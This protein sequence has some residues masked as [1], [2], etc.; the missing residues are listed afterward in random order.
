MP[1]KLIEKRFVKYS[2]K[3]LAFYLMISIV[4]LGSG[5]IYLFNP[6]TVKE[7]SAAWFNDDWGYR[8]LITFTH[9]ADITSDRSVT[10]TLDTA[11]LISAGIMQSDCDDTRFTDSGGNLLFFDL[12]GTCNNAST[13]YEAILPKIYN[14]ANLFYVYYGNPQ[15]PNTEIDS[16]TFSALT[17][18]GGDPSLSDP[19]S[20]GNQEK[21]PAPIMYWKM[22]EANG[23]TLNDSSS[24]NLDG[25][26]ADIN[27]WNAKTNCVSGFCNIFSQAAFYASIADNAKLDFGATDSF[28]VQSWVQ[29]LGASSATTHILNKSQDGTAGGYKLYM[30]ASGDFC[31]GIDDD[32][33]FGPDVSA[34]TSGVDFDDNRWHLVSGVRNVTDDKLYLYVD[35]VERA[36][37]SDT[38]TGSLANANS[39]YIGIDR[40]GTTGTFLGK[41][42]EVKVYNYARSSAQIKADLTASSNPHGISASLGGIPAIGSYKTLSDG[43]VGMWALNEASGNAND[44]SGNQNT[45]TESSTVTR[46]AG[47]FANGGDYE[48]TE[49][50]YHYIADNSLLSLTSSLSLAAWIKPES[51]TASTA[52]DIAGKWDGSNESYLLQQYGDEI[53]F[54][55]DSSSNYVETSSAN[56]S[57]GVW[58]HVLG[59]YDA[60]SATAKIYINGI[61]AATTTTGTIPTSVGDDAGRFH[62]GAEDSTTSAA[63]FYDGVLDEVRIYN[64]T[65]GFQEAS[66]LA[67]YAPEACVYYKLDDESTTIKDY[68]TCGYNGAVNGSV[69]NTSGKFG[70]GIKTDGSTGYIDAG[71][72]SIL[73]SV[74]H[75]S[76]TVW[77]KRTAAGGRGLF[78]TKYSDNTHRVGFDVL[79][80]GLIYLIVRNNDSSFGTIPSN[81]TNW[82]HVAL[83]FDGT[84]GS[85]ITRLQGYLDG[86]KQALSFNPNQNVPALTHTNTANNGDLEIGRS[87]LFGLYSAGSVDEFKIYN[88]PL[89]QKQVQDDMN[90]DHPAPGSPVGSAVANWKFEEGTGT[91]AHDSY[92]S[93][94]G[95]EDLTLSTATSAWNNSGKFG[96]AWSG[97]G[98]RWLSRSDDD[99]LDFTATED[100]SLSFWMNSSLASAANPSS[101]EYIYYKAPSGASNGGYGIYANTSGQV[102]FGID[103][104]NTSFPEDST[105]TSSDVY[106][107]SWHY[108]TAVKTGTSSLAMYV[109]GKSNGTADTSISSTTNTLANSSTLYVGDSNGADGGDEFN[110]YLDE[111]KIFRTALS[112]SQII[113]DM[114]RGASQVLGSL[115]SS[116]STSDSNQAAS[117]E[118]CV[119]GDSTSCATPV[120]RWDFEEGTGT[121]AGDSS[122]NNNTGTLSGNAA[123]KSGKNGKGLSLDGSGDYVTV[124]DATSLDLTTAF[125]IE[126][127]VKPSALG[128]YQVIVSKHYGTG[129]NRSYILYIDSSNNV[130]VKIDSD[131]IFGSSYFFTATPNTAFVANN[132]YHIVAVWN[133]AGSD[134][135]YINGI[136]HAL[137][138]S[139]TK[140]AT[141]YSGGADFEIGADENGTGGYF[142]GKIDNVRVFNYARTSSQAAWD[143]NRGAPSAYW[144]MDECQGGSINDSAGNSLTGTLTIGAA[145][146][147]DT[148]GTCSTSSSAWGGPNND[149]AGKRNYTVDL[150]GTDDYIQV[151][152]NAVLDFDDTQDLTISGWFYRDTATTDDVIAAKRNSL[153]TSTDTGYVLYLDATNDNLVFEVSDGTDEY[154]LTSTSSFT[155]TGWYHFSV[156]WDEDSAANSEIYINGVDDNATDSGTIGNVGAITNALNLRIG[157]ESD[158]GSY[159]D[160]RID[161]LKIFP[162]ALTTA[163]IKYNYN[164]SAIRMGPATGIP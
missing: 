52:F 164:Y 53:R 113:V 9:N 156:V 133:A 121:S 28:S 13:T 155:S 114:N 129:N 50:D 12:T 19:T 51:T 151:T 100:F 98:S 66:Q 37:A 84:Q 80:D 30:D 8:H 109:D 106:D 159:F 83:V 136:S 88:Y 139:G 127:W 86:V 61:E 97:G 118:Y 110:G 23:T 138:T 45:L 46:V 120:G 128:S 43:M 54:Y 152:D 18:S 108:I 92:S 22:D 55:I 93:T 44:A 115:S 4:I 143:Y 60:N 42:D 49:S 117:Q 33:S 158:G 149:G 123:Y 67:N 10:F 70:G 48:S 146:S 140:P 122:G 131:G 101:T 96:K 21:A 6:F 11:E 99:D 17:P 148:A 73:D 7:A 2:K 34:C 137:T 5:L 126:A 107:N 25:T 104:D 91:T 157:S 41:M 89:N 76:M 94:G 95:A 14:G 81:D 24:N 62:I 58:T 82:H 72:I 20:S 102:C 56:L 130:Q 141:A 74:S 29:K 135:I 162:Y 78:V 1:F 79:A 35:G 77:F 57:T 40:N 65:L 142:N 105:C 38:T 64:K 71:D 75:F 90:G 161:D 132:W 103:D 27:S 32:S 163:L 16:S 112:V 15:A 154:K 36:Q 31:F 125:T 111:F 144:K 63:N 160:G 124:A 3:A 47:K 150:D 116:N 59:V 119:P 39:L 85:N 145:G 153:D 26:L 68:S 69:T 134:A 147:E 87:N